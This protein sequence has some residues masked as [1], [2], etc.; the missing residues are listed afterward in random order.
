MANATFL[1]ASLMKTTRT[2]RRFTAWIASFAILLAALA[3]SI[4]Q[5]IAA[6]STSNDWAEVCTMEGAKLVK[7]ADTAPHKSTTHKL[8]HFEHCPFCLAHAVAL[9]LPP[10][11]GIQLPVAVG[12]QILPPLFYQASRP[13]FAWAAAQPR[14]PPFL[15]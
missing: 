8:S 14:A 12:T 5:A 7:V 6:A 11:S 10:D 3:P 9:G 15:S 1:H 2:M 13:L 4:S